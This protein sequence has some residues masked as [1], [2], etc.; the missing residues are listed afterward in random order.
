MK[1]LQNISPRDYQKAIV[2]TAKNNNT[3]AI[4]PTGIGKTLIAIMLSIE[5]LK[6]FPGKKVL[7]LA[8]TK[9]LVE[10]HLE[11]FKKVLPELFAD[12]QIFT[13][14]VKAE[15]RKKI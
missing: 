12:L 11:S 15:S 2:E 13:G 3:L 5:R 6:R 4:L 7:M 14:I 1:E 10:Q 9:P 8:P